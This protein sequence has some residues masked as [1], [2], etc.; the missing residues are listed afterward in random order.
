[1]N[2]LQTRPLPRA[3]IARFIPDPRGVKAF[4]ALQQDTSSQYDVLT[5]G[6]FLTLDAEPSLGSERIFTPAT[7]ELVGDD[8]GANG[9]YTLGLADTAVVAGTYGDAAHTV[10]V[11]ADAKGRLTG[12][13]AFALNTSNITEG[14]NLYYTDTRA[15]GAL[16]GVSGVSY[17]GA[18][19]AFSLDTASSRNVDHSAVSIS[20]GTGLTGGG[21]LTASRTLA[22]A[23]SGVTAGTYANPTSITVDAYGRVVAIS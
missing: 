7:G 3:D 12:V 2:N 5:T 22:L 11:T 20:A 18:T 8:G 15:R 17:N 10:S 6:Q 19:G 21:D 14:T 16:S 1:M 23:A 9:P 4:E 13:A